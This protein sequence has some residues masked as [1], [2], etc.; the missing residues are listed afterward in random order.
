M[1]NMHLAQINVATAVA[2]LDDPRLADFAAQLGLSSI[3]A[4]QKTTSFFGSRT[5]MA[6]DGLSTHDLKA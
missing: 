5:A 2:P 6:Q 3:A 1:P 4:S